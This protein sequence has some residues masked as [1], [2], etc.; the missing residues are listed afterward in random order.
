MKSPTTTLNWTKLQNCHFLANL[1]NFSQ[2]SQNVLANLTKPIWTS[3]LI[4]LNNLR[5]LLL[6]LYKVILLK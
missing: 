3:Y 5:L 2:V 4:K 1:S 6:I